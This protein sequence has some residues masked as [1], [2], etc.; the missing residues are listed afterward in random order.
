MIRGLGYLRSLADLETVLFEQERYSR[1][2]QDWE[3]YR[4]EPNPPRRAE[5]NGEGE[6][7]EASS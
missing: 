3:A 5:W 2:D 4:S 1:P 6:R 7:S